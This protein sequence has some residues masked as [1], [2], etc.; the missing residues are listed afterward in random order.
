MTSFFAKERR[1]TT[2]HHRPLPDGSALLSG[3]TPPSEFAFRSDRLQMSYFKTTLAWTDPLP[4]AHQE[5]DECF[6]V[7]QG[8]L[9][10]EVEGERV[11][12]GPREFC[13]FP[14]G[15]YHRVV[16]V[17]PPIE[18]LILRGPS[19]SDKQYVESRKVVPTHFPTSLTKSCRSSGDRTPV[20]VRPPAKWEGWLIDWQGLQDRKLTHL[21]LV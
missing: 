20:V 5:S 15:T 2:F 3:P 17:H 14:R 16:E 10:V 6:L 7:L 9:I 11:T 4:H 13:G 8:T 18:C 21:K 1:V 19:G 12:I